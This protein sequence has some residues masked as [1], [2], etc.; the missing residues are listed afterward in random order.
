MARRKGSKELINVGYGSKENKFGVRFTASEMNKF[1]NEVQRLNKRQASYIKQMQTVRN[2]TGFA[3]DSRIPVEPL[4]E[5]K[6]TSLQ[7][8]TSKEE[9]NSYMQ[10]MR[11]Q[12]GQNYKTW[13]YNTE[14]ENFKQS[15]K[16]VFGEE[17]SRSLIR[18]VNKIPLDKL[19]NAFISRELE[20]TGWVY[21]D[22]E[23]SKLNHVSNQLDALLT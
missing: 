8:F 13:R 11:R 15:L 1:R 6:S 19:H 21:Y 10:R 18:M 2:S 7:R 5:K 14:K 23:N 9:F 4:F 3:L 17:N 16:S 12:G 20:H 22:P